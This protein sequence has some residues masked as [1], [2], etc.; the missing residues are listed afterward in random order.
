MSDGW[1]AREV[2]VGQ[3]RGALISLHT[4]TLQVVDCRY[5]KVASPMDQTRMGDLTYDKDRRHGYKL[6]ASYGFGLPILYGVSPKGSLNYLNFTKKDF[7]NVGLNYCDDDEDIPPIKCM[8]IEG[9]LLLD[10]QWEVDDI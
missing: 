3:L 1:G 4:L 5:Y 10:Y 8:P 7:D 9:G 6:D 2:N